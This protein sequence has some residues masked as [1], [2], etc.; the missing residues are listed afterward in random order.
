MQ[1]GAALW[2]SFRE[3]G[4][5]VRYSLHTMREELRI[6]GGQAS[7]F[8]KPEGLWVDGDKLV[9]CNAGSKKLWQ[10]DLKTYAVADCMEFEEPVHQ[11]VRIDD[12]ELVVLDS[13]VYLL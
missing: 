4:V 6:G 8:S 9:V 3:N 1:Y 12:Y 11:Y 13:G 5:L 10:V 2:A 7:T